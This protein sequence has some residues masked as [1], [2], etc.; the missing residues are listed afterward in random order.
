MKDLTQSSDFQN[1]VCCMKDITSF[2]DTIKLVDDAAIRGTDKMPEKEVSVRKQLLGVS[3][4]IVYRKMLEVLHDAL[5]Y[6]EA[7]ANEVKDLVE[8]AKV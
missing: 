6:F 7:T 3:R 8:T 4:K 2:Y 5:P 1:L